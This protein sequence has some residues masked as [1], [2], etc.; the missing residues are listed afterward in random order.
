MAA[1]RRERS[2][3]RAGARHRRSRR[4]AGARAGGRS[5][6]P[7]SPTARSTARSPPRSPSGRRTRRPRGFAIVAL[8]KL[9][10]RE[11]NYSSD[12]DLDLPLRSRDAAATPREEPDQAALRIGQRV[13]EILQKRDRGRLCLP[14]RPAAAALARGDADRAA[15]RRGDLLLRKRGFALGARGLHPRPRRG[16]RPGARPLFPRG[17]PSLRLAALARLSAR[18]ARSARSA[19]GS[20]TIMRR[21]RRSAPA[22]TSSAAAAAS[23]RSSSSSRSTSSSMAAASRSC[24]RAGTL[25]ALA[26]LA[27]AGRIDADDA[28]ALRR[29]LSR[30]S[31]RSSTGCRWS[32][33]ARPTACP[34]TRPRSTMSRACTGSPDGAALLDLLAPACRARRRAL[35]HARRGAKASG[36]PRIRSALDAALARGG[37][38]RAGGGAGADRGLALGQGPLA[39][40]RPRRA[41]RSRRCCR[42]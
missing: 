10:G 40:H 25:D 30:C 41:R 1:V 18:S 27:E 16:G 12:L 35:R 23:A 37:L 2:A 42:C 38:R 17:D 39:A 14:H 21:A 24:A 36:C 22:T 34:P 6:C 5:R 28:A 15:G 19:A 20:A 32:T 3:A 7:T 8:G 33:T 11:L 13:V 26:A 31:A 4:G 29:G 9:G